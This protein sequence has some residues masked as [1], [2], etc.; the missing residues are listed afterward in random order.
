MAFTITE[1][2]HAERGPE[3]TLQMPLW[4]SPTPVEQTIASAATHQE[5]AA[6]AAT[7]RYV[8]VCADAAFYYTFGTAPVATTSKGY[9]PASVPMFVSVPVGQSYKISILA[10]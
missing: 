3:G 1:F 7:T 10:A 5:S 6:F 8:L 9:W 4:G 2:Q